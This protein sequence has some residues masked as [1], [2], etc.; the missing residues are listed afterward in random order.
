MRRTNQ[1]RRFADALLKIVPIRSFRPERRAGRPCPLQGSAPDRGKWPAIRGKFPC[2]QG[3]PVVTK[4]AVSQTFPRRSLCHTCT[5]IFIYAGAKISDAA[6]RFPNAEPL[7]P[8]TDPLDAP[9]VADAMVRSAR[10][11][12]S[13]PPDRALR[14]RAVTAAQRSKRFLQSTLDALTSHV[15]VLDEDGTIVA[16]NRAWERFAEENGGTALSC[17]VGANYLAVCGEAY[18]MRAQEAPSVIAGIRA[19]M[20]GQRPEFSL[21]YPC[22]SP[23]QQRWFILR[24][25]CFDAEGTLRA[26]IT[27]EN[28]TER[29]Q[30]EQTLRESEERYRQIVETTLEGVWVLNREFRTTYVNSQMAMML[31]YSE[32]EMSGLTLLEFVF[33][34]DAAWMKSKMQGSQYGFHFRFDGRY[35]RRDGT[36]L[37]LLANTRPIWEDGNF[38]GSFG[39]FTDIT[40]RKQAEEHQR[41][42]LQGLHMV[43]AVADE[44]LALPTMDTLLHWAVARAREQLGLERCSI[45]LLV[46]GDNEAR[47]TF[48]TDTQGHTTDERHQRFTR[49]VHWTEPLLHMDFTLPGAQRWFIDPM[50]ALMGSDPAHGEPDLH[51]LGKTGWVVATPILSSDGP[52]GVLFNDTAI[53]GAPVDATLQEVMV[54]YCSLLGNIIAR[55]RAEEAVQSANLALETRVLERTSALAAANAELQQATQEAERANHAKSE[56]LSRMSHELRTPL[57][58]ILGFGQILNEEAL[59]PLQRESVGYIL[60]GGRH[61]LDLINEVLDITR[62]EAGHSDLSLEAISLADIVQETC[63]L[64]RPL[65]SQHAIGIEEAASLRDT[66]VLADRQRLKQ[67]LLNLLANAIKYNRP[68]GRVE[69]SC[70]SLADERVR[71]IVRDTGV[72][73]APEDIPSL[74]TPFE[75]LGAIHTDI[76]GTGLG[77]ALS[78]RLATAMGGTLH[79]ES[80]LGQGSAFVIELP[81]MASP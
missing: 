60:K 70:E 21:E 48:G 13:L 45:Y 1:R 4:C 2:L 31:G 72:G 39:M 56:F 19:V 57:N 27:H 54:V 55:Q 35:R 17:G 73:I 29:K 9:S 37:W 6:K 18:G 52:Q 44:L 7:L 11:A 20:A 12:H 23:T 71:L 80:V 10:T 62:V 58:S 8:R 25:T 3:P 61:L 14:K 36:E 75:R 74:F 42:L 81:C 64:V 63:A 26:V 41:A 24:V 49:S 65:A 77:L 66:S 67:V 79:A 5:C 46:P 33:D 53:S 16:V 28:I 40:A 59:S 34:E 15:A 47:G 76:E 22:H 78:Q 69:I 51:P 32:E 30:A 43:V 50:H 38:T 68:A